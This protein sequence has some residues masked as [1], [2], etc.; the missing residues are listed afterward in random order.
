MILIRLD[1]YY[2]CLFIVLCDLTSTWI[3]KRTHEHTHSMLI[4]SHS[5]TDKHCLAQRIFRLHTNPLTLTHLHYSH[6]THSTPT[7][8]PTHPRYTPPLTQNTTHLYTI[9]RSKGDGIEVSINQG[10]L[11]DYDGYEPFTS[12]ARTTRIRD[13]TV[14]SHTIL[15][16]LCYSA[17]PIL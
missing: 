5:H 14:S 13:D 4:L 16:T 8:P 11:G 12:E 10:P 15:Y 1:Y 9:H 3:F 17:I 7:T 2:N 6:Y